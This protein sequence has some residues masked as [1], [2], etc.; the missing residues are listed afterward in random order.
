MRSASAFRP[1]SLRNRPLAR[2]PLKSSGEV[3]IRPSYT[4]S[5][6]LSWPRQLPNALANSRSSVAVSIVTADDEAGAGVVVGDAELVSLLAPEVDPFL[7]SLD[8]ATGAAAEAADAA[9]DREAFRPL[10]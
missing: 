8:S 4:D 6:S 10:M 3:W 5:A 7:G 2:Y 9:V 1:L